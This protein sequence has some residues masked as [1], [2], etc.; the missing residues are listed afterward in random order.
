MKRENISKDSRLTQ[1]PSPENV[2]KQIHG[3]E[4][5]AMM[6]MLALYLKYFFFPF[7]SP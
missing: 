2:G 3:F 6:D 5:N 4:G 7:S 1:T